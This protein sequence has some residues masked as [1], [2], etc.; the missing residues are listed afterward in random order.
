MQ[1]AV[2]IVS[3]VHHVTNVDLCN[4]TTNGT[5]KFRGLRIVGYG[6]GTTMNW[7]PRPTRCRQLVEEH[8]EANQRR[9]LWAWDQE[10]N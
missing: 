1:R 3:C 9:K 2:F 6:Y 7:H 8:V 5:Q 10:R 4:N